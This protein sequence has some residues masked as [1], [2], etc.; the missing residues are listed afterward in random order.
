MATFLFFVGV[1]LLV[2]AWN[3]TDVGISN[4]WG[5]FIG[6]LGILLWFFAAWM[7]GHTL[8]AAI[9]LAAFVFSIIE[10]VKDNRRH[11]G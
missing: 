9:L 11:S 8:V 6:T 1:V 10:S 7:A 2:L 4:W 5:N 3:D